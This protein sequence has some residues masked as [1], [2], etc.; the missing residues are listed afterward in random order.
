MAN[1]LF[2]TTYAESFLEFRLPLVKYLQQL[3]YQ[4]Y[5]AA[6]S[7]SSTY[8]YKLHQ[9]GIIHLHYLLIEI[10]FRSR[11]IYLL[12]QLFTIFF[13][14]KFSIVCPTLLNLSSSALYVPGFLE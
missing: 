5:L 2:V 8:L 7:P 3:G 6:P 14:Y 9:E 4:I 12:C 10:L 13:K 1:F 11:V